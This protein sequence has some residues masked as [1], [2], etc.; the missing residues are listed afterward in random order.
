MHK[1]FLTIARVII[2]LNIVLAVYL[3]IATTTYPSTML[4]RETIPPPPIKAPTTTLTINITV[5]LIPAITQIN[6]TLDRHVESTLTSREDTLI[7]SYVMGVYSPQIMVLILGLTIG[8]TSVALIFE[9]KASRSRGNLEGAFQMFKAAEIWYIAGLIST[10]ILLAY[11][12][13][14]RLSYG[15]IA[16]LILIF[17]SSILVFFAW[18][19]LH[20]YRLQNKL[21]RLIDIEA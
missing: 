21:L 20:I 8:V 13:L 16:Y 7:S 17:E 11:L 14:Y 6:E 15:L 3:I 12:I 2:A 19:I 1:P 18:R 10:S 5:T 4:S 9:F